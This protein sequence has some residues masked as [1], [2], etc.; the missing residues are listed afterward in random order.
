LFKSFE[1]AEMSTSRKFGGTGL[2]LAIS[3]S[4]IAAMD[5]RIWIESSPGKG[6]DFGFTVN[7]P[8]GDEA[9]V[10]A[11]SRQNEIDRKNTNFEK[12]RLLLVEDIDINREI[13]LGL[14]AP[15]K[16]SIEIAKNGAEAVELFTANP[17]RYDVVFMD[18]QMPEMD[19][20]EATRRI[21]TSGA[22]NA[23]TIPIIAMTANVF[24]E[25]VDRCIE[26]GMNDHIGKP[27]DIL[28]MQDILSA[29]LT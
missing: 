14:L 2:G 13:V 6:S 27:I 18:L 29:Y 3:K 12:Y 21:R 8:R 20:Y 9:A 19:G 26:A 24:R 5:G 4:L 1:Q 15:T 11:P 28:A 7:I 23:T 22:P 25:D 16:L 17:E 10:T